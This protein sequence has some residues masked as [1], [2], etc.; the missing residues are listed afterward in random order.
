MA[1]AVPAARANLYGPEQSSCAPGGAACY[2]QDVQGYWYGTG[3]GQVWSEAATYTYS[4]N[5]NPSDGYAYNE[6]YWP[7]SQAEAYAQDYGQTNWIG[8]A[9]CDDEGSGNVC[10]HW[11]TQF[12]KWH[13]P[14]NSSEKDH[15]VCHEFG[16]TMGLRHYP[17]GTNP[18][19]MQEPTSRRFSDHDYFHIDGYL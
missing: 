16:H 7:F 4:V 10:L 18:S 3:F 12:N 9:W 8:Q 17:N 2:P 5:I 13:G 6:T 14:F 19:C 15:L 11:I 1:I